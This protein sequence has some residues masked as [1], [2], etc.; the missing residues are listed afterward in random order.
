MIGESKK[1]NWLLGA[2]FYW[3]KI[4]LKTTFS[5]DDNFFVGGIPIGENE[6]GFQHPPF[7]ICDET[8][9][10]LIGPCKTK[11]SEISSDRGEYFSYTVFGDLNYELFSDFNVSFGMRIS[12]DDK[13]F[14]SNLPLANSVSAVII[15]DNLLGPNTAGENVIN[16]KV[17]TGFQPRLS[18]DY[19]L[20][21]NFLVYANYAR[22]YKA[23]GFNN[24]SVLAFDEESSNALEAGLKSSMNSDKI[25]LNT[26][27][28]YTDYNDLQVQTIGDVSGLL[29]IDNAAEVGSKGIE[30][31]ASFSVGKE[32]TISG[33]TGIGQARYRN[34]VEGDNNFSGNTPGRSPD[35]S[36]GL[37]A[38][39]ERKFKKLGFVH[40]RADYGYQ[41]RIYFSRENLDQLSQ[42][43]YGVLNATLGVRAIFNTKANVQLFCN[44]LLD[45]E[46]LLQA[47]RPI[48]D[49]TS[50]IKVSTAPVWG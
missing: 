21:E 29:V 35:Y 38:Q 39:Y 47:E 45:E 14:R 26:A 36:F 12:I 24:V 34:Y 40:W 18:L 32:F 28:Y 4:R 13:R 10:M 46:Y 20:N 1:L 25:K 50:G 15:G 42:E 49:R 6:F 8:S 17:F 27:I 37:I 9:D 41:S 11:A 16:E 23:G 5:Y 30:V 7:N 31:E 2:G 44:N 19:S 43:G 33:N 22:G 48:W 3:E